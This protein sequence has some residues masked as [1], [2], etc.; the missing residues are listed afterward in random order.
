M[1]FLIALLFSFGIHAE[2]AEKLEA[3]QVTTDIDKQATPLV[4][5]PGSQT[6]DSAPEIKKRV[7]TTLE[8]AIGQT[9][10]VEFTGGP[11]T[12]AQI[13]Q[14][15]GLDAGRILILEDGVRQNFQSGHNGRVFGDFSLTESVEIVKGP[16]S[17]LYGSG[18][19][20]GVISFRRATA[21]DFIKRY[22]RD[23]GSQF[24]VDYESAN[25]GMGGRV[26]AFRK[27]DWFEP[28]LSYRF[29]EA[30]DVRLGDGTNLQYSGSDNTDVYSSLGFRLG[31]KQK[32]TLKVDSFA[33]DSR[34]PLDPEQDIS[35]STNELGDNHV[36]KKD[37]VGDYAYQAEHF[38]IRAKPFWR[39]TSVRKTRLS[40]GR[41]DTQEIATT[42]IDA[43]NN[44]RKNWNESVSSV[45]TAGVD[46]FNDEVRGDRNGGTLDSFPN[47]SNRQTGL[48]LQPS[49]TAGKL[50][51]TPGLRYDSYELKD[52]SGAAAANSAE[53]TSLKGYAT[54][55]YA[56]ERIVFAGWGQAFNAPR[57]QDIYITGQHFPGN[58]FQP[59]PDLKPET[60]ETYE[61]GTK[62]R[63]PLGQE[64]LVSLNGTY[65]RTEAHDFIARQVDMGAGT[66]IFA[67]LDRVRLEGYELSALLQKIYWGAGVSYAQVRSLDKNSGEPLSDTMA[68][69]WMATLQYY[70]TDALELGTDLRYAL[71][72]DRVPSGVSET[73]GY[74]T[75]DFYGE[76]KWKDMEIRV[77]LNNAYDRDYQRHTSAIKDTGRDFRLNINWTF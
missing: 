5:A 37:A 4:V 21:A 62:N 65:Y 15:R 58:F 19:M 53:H 77:R 61:A 40:D 34:I 59:N 55:E 10:G 39:K 35:A 44:W 76:Y 48:Y 18:A 13:P 6:K 9:P 66:T 46:Y 3:I 24:A 73:P 50:T 2:E 49:L 11:R 43:W 23:Y 63:I 30:Q 36:A 26:T 60:S 27:F 17:S 38:D 28:L 70:A 1:S 42:G 64:T 45:V 33:D 74:F 22:K 69:Q 68:D 16:W 71:K 75:Q 25:Q 29:Y 7:P 8:G 67:N 12:Q 47:G 14:I 41:V 20:G 56:K 54:Y 51:L 52:S 32:F 31:E 57:L 72:Q